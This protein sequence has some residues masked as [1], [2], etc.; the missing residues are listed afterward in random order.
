MKKTI[1]L[2]QSA[3]ARLTDSKPF[4][5]PDELELE[6]NCK[7]Y[8]L[9]DA[10]ITLQNGKIKGR[11]KLTQPFYVDKA[12][13]VAGK[14]N[15]AI[16]LY[17]DGEMVKKW[18]VLPIIIKE[19]VFGITMF[20]ELGEINKKLDEINKNYVSK[21]EYVKLLKKTNELIEKQNELADTV[22]AIKENY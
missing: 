1:E 20:D 18:D 14:L 8:S 21:E 12:L 2:N 3:I 6:F 4:L 15:M 22:S 5:L 9:K 16:A 10:F 17:I 7:E 19:T 13:L 11:Y